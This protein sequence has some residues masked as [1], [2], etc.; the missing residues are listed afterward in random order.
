M[1]ER[2]IVYL[3]EREGYEVEY[4]GIELGLMDGGIDLVCKR[5]GETVVVQCKNWS[6]TKTIQR[7]Q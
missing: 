6:E 5:K 2:Y 7:L 1:Y 3:Y 4:R